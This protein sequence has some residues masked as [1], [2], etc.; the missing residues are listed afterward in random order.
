MAALQREVRELQAERVAYHERL[1]EADQARQQL[2]GQLAKLKG[3]GGGGG[4]GGG[5][6]GAKGGG[7]AQKG[8]SEQM[9]KRFARL[10]EAKEN[11]CSSLSQKLHAAHE[12]RSST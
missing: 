6:L 11:E 10:Q 1:S 4:G 9:R 5:L 3:G 2:Q 12:A 7:V 8:Y